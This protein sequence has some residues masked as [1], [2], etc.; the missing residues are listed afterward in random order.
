MNPTTA[1]DTEHLGFR[2]YFSRP[3]SRIQKIRGYKLNESFAFHPQVAA[4]PALFG[5]SEM[6]FGK[7][8]SGVGAAAQTFDV[9]LTAAP[10]PSQATPGTAVATGSPL[11]WLVALLAC[12]AM[13]YGLVAS[14]GAGILRDH[15]L[16]G[17]WQPA[18]DLRATEGK[19]E[20]TN[21][22]ITFCS[23]KIISVARPDQPAVTY[24]FM[25]LFSSGGGETLVPARST[26]DRAAI[27][28]L[29]AAETKLWN[30]TVSFVSV[31][32]LVALFTFSSLLLFWRSLNS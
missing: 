25:M 3:S 6:A 9:G 24:K 2:R 5:E 11:R 15:R 4:E 32:G 7:R 22:V 29:Y 16:S 12:G 20:R 17:T 10:A 27:T 26:T 14:Y 31:A 28:V 8:Q 30:R 13:L 18:Y 19:C 23:T 1:F 21:F